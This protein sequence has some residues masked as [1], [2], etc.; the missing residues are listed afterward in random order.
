MGN[1][2]LLDAGP[3][4][5]QVPPNVTSLVPARNATTD[6][7]LNL[8]HHV[9]LTAYP[10][11]APDEATVRVRNASTG[12]VVHEDVFDP[13]DPATLESRW[14]APS[15]GLFNVTFE[16][17]D[18]AVGTRAM[19]QVNVTDEGLIR[20]L[21]SDGSYAGTDEAFGNLD[22]DGEKDLY[23][24]VHPPGT[25]D[26]AGSFTVTVGDR[27]GLGRDVN[28]HLAQG[29]PEVLGTDPDNYTHHLDGPDASHSFTAENVSANETWGM[30]VAS[31]ASSVAKYEATHAVDCGDSGGDGGG[32]GGGDCTLLGFAGRVYRAEL[33]RCSAVP[34]PEAPWMV[35]GPGI[36]GG[37]DGPGSGPPGAGGAQPAPR[38]EPE[39]GLGGGP[40]GA[41]AGAVAGIVVLASLAG[42]SRAFRGRDRSWDWEPP[43]TPP[44]SG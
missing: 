42:A 23:S 18:A 8:S 3:A 7:Q 10:G 16:A 34:G 22:P 36:A 12:A 44:S 41:A 35:P 39:P 37:G 24:L 19:H 9:N 43:G 31:N 13:Q 15:A 40:A 27:E 28:M 17:V 26:C 11:L 2:R 14:E 1:T 25:R 33:K 29:E 6:P 4:D 32:G 21:T 5:V 30:L 20:N 38:A